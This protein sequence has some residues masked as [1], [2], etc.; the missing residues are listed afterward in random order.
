MLSRMRLRTTIAALLLLLVASIAACGGGEQS[1]LTLQEYLE[2]VEV[3]F[4]DEVEQLLALGEDTNATPSSGDSI[5]VE[6]QVELQ[7][8]RDSAY[9]SI[10]NDT[11]SELNGIDPP[12]EARNAH[13][14]Y[15]DSLGEFV[16]SY[17]QLLSSETYD[18]YALAVADLSER[19]EEAESP[20]EINQLIVEMRERAAELNIPDLSI[21]Q[22]EVE[23]ACR[24]FVSLA[25]AISAGVNLNCE[26]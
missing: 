9:V 21:F 15:T 4:A 6:K 26:R 5:S 18:D 1:T 16:E 10:L 11:I 3:V 12:A 20:D 7:R 19:L 22:S 25:A 8:D 13:S 23:E 2:R 14:A 17:E 24:E